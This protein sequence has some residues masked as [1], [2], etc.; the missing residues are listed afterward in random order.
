MT[1][2]LIPSPRRG[3]SSQGLPVVAV[4]DPAYWSVFDAATLLGPPTLSESR[5]RNLI[6]LANLRPAGK[7]HNGSR[8]RHVRVYRAAEL[9]DAYEKV[10]QL[11]GAAD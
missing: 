5:V 3:W 11:T 10:A 7:R 4:D 8:K 1:E 6:A 2:P 9:L